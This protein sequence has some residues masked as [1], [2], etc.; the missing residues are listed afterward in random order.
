MYI[1]ISLGQITL[2]KELVLFCKFNFF[3]ETQYISCSY[4]HGH[5]HP[6][7]EYTYVTLPLRTPW[8]DWVGGSLAG[9]GHVVYH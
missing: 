4:M 8:R 1:V 6:Y 9:G 3:F 2:M 7:D 5:I